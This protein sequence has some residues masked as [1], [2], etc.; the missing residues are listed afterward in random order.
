MGRNR[1]DDTRCHIQDAIKRSNFRRAKSDPEIPEYKKKIGKKPFKVI[2]G[3]YRGFK[4]CVFGAYKTRGS[5]ETAMKTFKAVPYWKDIKM[6][7][8]EG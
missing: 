7:I 5:A 1:M 3:E 6:R 8:K 4:E 2:A